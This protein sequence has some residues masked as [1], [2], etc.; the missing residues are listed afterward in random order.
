MSDP[1][2]PDNDSWYAK[3][4]PPVIALAGW[5]MPGAGYWLIGQR[6]RGIIVGA[7]IIVLYLSGLLVAGVRVIE[8][9]GYDSQSGHQIR[10]SRGRIVRPSERFAYESA[11]WILTHGGLISEIA[12][13]PWFVGQVLAG[14]IAVVSAVASVQAAQQAYEQVQQAPDQPPLSTRPHAPLE[15]VGVLYTAVAGMLNLLVIIDSTY[16]AGQRAAGQQTQTRL[17]VAGGQ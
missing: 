14:P 3:L 7:S 15:A 5:L 6:A 17:R 2:P 8:V 1:Q 16:R 9:P 12:N 13:K 11:G 10:V 4:P